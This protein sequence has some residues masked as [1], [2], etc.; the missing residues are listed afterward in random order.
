M[1]GDG[2]E[3]IKENIKEEEEGKI[4]KDRQKRTKEGLYISFFPGI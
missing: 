1:S 3:S 2:G 4:D